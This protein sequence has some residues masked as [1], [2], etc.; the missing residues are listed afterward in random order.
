VR[1]PF[2]YTGAARTAVLTLKFRS[3]R[4]LVPLMGQL[5]CDRLSSLQFDVVVPVP[6]SPERQRLRGFNQ[7]SLLGEH[8]A[9]RLDV[10]LASVALDRVERPSQRSLGVA[11]R[12]S[13]LRGAFSCRGE[14]AGERVLLVDDVVT[15]G[16][17][18]SVCADTLADAGASRICVLAFARDL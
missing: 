7:A 18:A 10:P 12:L 15:T 8:V 2:A 4:Y 6:L 13:N 1:A 11:G 16:A 14:L 3:G 9:L 17:T 5:L